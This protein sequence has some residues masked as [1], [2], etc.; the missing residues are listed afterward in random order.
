MEIMLLVFTLSY[1]ILKLVIRSICFFTIAEKSHKI[2]CPLLL[3]IIFKVNV[4]TCES[5]LI[6]DN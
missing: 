3:S 4:K 1:K 6:I 2:H 5:L